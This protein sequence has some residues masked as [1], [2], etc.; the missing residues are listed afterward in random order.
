VSDTDIWDT[1][2]KLGKIIKTVGFWLGM[3]LGFHT[4]AYNKFPK[5]YFAVLKL[6]S[7]RRNTKWDINGHFIINRDKLP[8]IYESIENILSE[9]YKNTR[10]RRNVNLKNKKSYECGDYV[11][12]VYDDSDMGVL[13]NGEVW[14]NISQ[15]HVPLDVAKEYL[16][17]LRELFNKIEKELAPKKV[18]YS[19]DVFF[20]KNK[21]PFFGL[22]IQR[23]GVEHVE[24]FQCVFPISALITKKYEPTDRKYTLRVFKEKITINESTFDNLEEAAIRALL[25]G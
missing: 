14:I 16:R 18:D 24:D 25:L 17:D 11:L 21:N 8:Y 20:P 13:S 9:R 23:L 1:L 12:W 6:F 3:L 5:Y 4:W 22:M 2:Y 15:L 7:R 10:Y 19:M